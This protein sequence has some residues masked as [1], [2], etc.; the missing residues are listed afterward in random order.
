[1]KTKSIHP[2]FFVVAGGASRPS[3]K[4]IIW[5]L[6]ILTV[7]FTATGYSDPL[8]INIL[9]THYTTTASITYFDPT[10]A[11]FSRTLTATVP[12]SDS[13]YGVVSGALAA[14]NNAGLFEIYVNTPS[15][16][17]IEPN[18][19]QNAASA[20]CTIWF[21]TLT[22]RTETI[23]IQFSGGDHWLSDCGA[24][25]SLLDVTSG[26]AVW[27]YGLPVPVGQPDGS[28][29]WAPWV[30]T[31]Y[32]GSAGPGTLTIDTDF[33]ADDIY[34]LTM[35]ASSLSGNYPDSPS[36]SLQIS[37]LEPVPEPSTF[38]LLGLG[39]LALAMVLGVGRSTRKCLWSVFS[40]A[41]ALALGA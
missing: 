39:S 6:L 4:T 32:P 13:L 29:S 11:N 41:T 37:G 38:A 40:P 30:Y 15:I 25:L 28:Y 20:T 8:P 12:I 7:T 18:I 9:D 33:K 10:T 22:S 34:Q 27:N 2:Y 17:Q 24:S 1:M 21:S 5:L 23:N 3:P 19:W 14:E 26:D 31:G 16:A 35:S 36:V